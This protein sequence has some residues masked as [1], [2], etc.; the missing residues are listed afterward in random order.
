VAQVHR[1]KRAAIDRNAL[2]LFHLSPLSHC[3]LDDPTLLR[4][5]LQLIE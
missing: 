1:I 2:P 4:L 5:L 3:Q